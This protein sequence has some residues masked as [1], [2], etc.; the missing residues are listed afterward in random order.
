M[1]I[2]RLLP[3]LTRRPSAQPNSDRHGRRP[4]D[5]LSPKCNKATNPAPIG[6]SS[7]P[8][9]PHAA[10]P[11]GGRLRPTTALLAAAG[12]WRPCSRSGRTKVRTSDVAARAATPRSTG[13]VAATAT[14]L[15][16]TAVPPSMPPG[17]SGADERA[18][19]RRHAVAPTAAPQPP[20]RPYPLRP[21]PH[22]RR[23]SE[24]CRST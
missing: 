23:P 3:Y 18:L 22:W 8:A 16:V 19:R 11:R 9:T 24:A 20:G 21:R 1:T 14:L 13:T 2:V 15:A 7:T 5:T 10:R 4:S 17:Q 12:H 6:G